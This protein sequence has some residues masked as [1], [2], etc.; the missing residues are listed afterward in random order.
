[1][2]DKS[3]D[4]GPGQLSGPFG[5]QFVGYGPVPRQPWRERWGE[6][7]LLA[8]AIAVGALLIIAVQGMM[9]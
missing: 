9:A 8:A 3:R 4:F 2:Q 5:P 1:M 6:T 7:V